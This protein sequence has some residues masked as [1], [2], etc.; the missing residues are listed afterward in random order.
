MKKGQRLLGL[1][2]G[3]MI[4]LS[5]LTVSVLAAMDAVESPLPE[6]RLEE[7]A[8]VLQATS[9]D[10]EATTTPTPT[11]TATASPSGTAKPVI[12]TGTCGE[13]LTWTLSP[14]GVLTIS[15]TGPMADYEAGGA[16]W[17]AYLSEI[18]VLVMEEGV[19]TVGENA[20]SDCYMLE[21]VTVPSTMTAVKDSAFAYC[22][23]MET[24]YFRGRDQ[25]WKRITVGENNDAFLAL[26][27]ECLYADV[28]G[29]GAVNVRDIVR[30]MLCVLGGAEPCGPA[31]G[32]YDGSGVMDLRDVLRL[33][34]WFGGENATLE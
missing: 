28:N 13:S 15:G 21:E 16:P 32:D 3:L 6:I 10:T 25:D 9:G 17:Y 12:P 1:I 22:T 20:F 5:L 11:P 31:A 8:P 2:L 4:G 14:D 7:D 23:W 24:L 27:P 30:L 19:T 29:D 26:V 18:T 34:R 33:I